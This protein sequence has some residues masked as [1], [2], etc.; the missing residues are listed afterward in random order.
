MYTFILNVSDNEY[1]CILKGTFN[2]FNY[3]GIFSL[4]ENI[5]LAPNKIPK[6]PVQLD[7]KFILCT[8]AQ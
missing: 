4:D 5:L 6:I 2:C 8:N 3:R 1:L 7:S